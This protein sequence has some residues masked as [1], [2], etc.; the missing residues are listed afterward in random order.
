MLFFV[1]Q[2]YMT[3]CSNEFNRLLN[4]DASFA[5][6]AAQTRDRHPPYAPTFFSFE[7]NIVAAR[8]VV[9]HAEINCAQIVFVVYGFK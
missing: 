2:P 7:T 3:R 8:E 4:V 1:I 6:Y 9:Y 5:R